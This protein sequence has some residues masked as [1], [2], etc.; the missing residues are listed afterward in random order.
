MHKIA[1]ELLR[2]ITERL[3]KRP[4]NWLTYQTPA[5][6]FNLV[7]TGDLQ[8]EFIRARE[9]AKSFSKPPGKAQPLTGGL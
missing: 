1:E 3:N 9:Q 4:H 7:L 8:V 2:N 6:V 5:E